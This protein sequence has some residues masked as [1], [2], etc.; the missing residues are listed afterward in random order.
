MEA[1]EVP[2]CGVQNYFFLTKIISF[3]VCFLKCK[4]Q[5]RD[6]VKL[7]SSYLDSAHCVEGRKSKMVWGSL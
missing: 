5:V 1:L 3:S 7:A 4:F 6:K 2:K